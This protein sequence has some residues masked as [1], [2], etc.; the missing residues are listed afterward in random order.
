M[1]DLV[2]GSLPSAFLAL[3]DNQYGTHNGSDNGSVAQYQQVYAPTFGRA[4]AVVYPAV[5]NGDYGDNPNIPPDPSGFSQYFTGAGVFSRIAADGGNNANLTTSFYYSFDLGGWHIVA[6]NSQCAAITGATPGAGGCG[7]GSDEEKWLKADL[8]AH[9]GMCTLAYWH[10]P[11]WNSGRL[12]N[13]TD[14]AAFWTDLYNAHADVVLNGHGN[15]HYERFLPQ[16][17]SGNPD[18]NGIREFIVSNGGYSHGNPP[19]GNPPVT[20]GDPTT[21]VVSDYSSFGVLQLTLHPTS[22]DWKFL[23]A[24]G[25]T[26]TDSGSASCHA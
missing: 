21:S 20:P 7:V 23:P 16:D 5:G 6:L 14:T 26:L 2:A 15:N 8:A 24:A 9:P 19:S 11:R 4:N 12:G 25:S 13:Q 18:P 1:S 10:V 17:P 3:G 22:Y